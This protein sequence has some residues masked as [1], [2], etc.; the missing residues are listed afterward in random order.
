V[1]LPPP[2][3]AEAERALRLYALAG[4]VDGGGWGIYP[5]R[6][7]MIALRR[8]RLLAALGDFPAAES[9]VRRLWES[10]RE[11]PVAAAL[12]R[13]LAAQG[14]DD[15]AE[16]LADEAVRDNPSWWRLAEE[17]VTG[18]VGM[19]R[20]DEAIAMARARH[21]ALP[22]D[23]V[24]MRRLSLLLIEHG[25]APAD[26]EEGVRLVDRTIEIDPSNP[27]A[28]RVRAM[29]MVRLERREDAIASVQRALELAPGDPGLEDALRALTAP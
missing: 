20:T 3:R 8:A 17:R 28:W 5:G 4:P 23:I 29:G 16:S 7:R 2:M 6:E 25:D 14:R 1:D 26:V 27:N 12:V 22:D 10:R 15:E 24:A 18:L 13:L 11:E 19:G 21:A 9:I